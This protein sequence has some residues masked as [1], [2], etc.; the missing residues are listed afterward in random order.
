MVNSHETRAR[1]GRAPNLEPWLFALL[2]LAHLLPIWGV[3]HFVTDDGPTHLY[4]AWLLKEYLTGGS[5]WISEIYRLNLF[6]FPNLVSHALMTPLLLA[7]PPWIVWKLALSLHV[8]ALPLSARYALVGL[9]RRNAWLSWLAFPFIF[10]VTF[11][12]GFLNLNYSLA[13]WFLIIGFWWRRRLEFC[14]RDALGLAA[15]GVLIYFC[16]PVATA[17]V[18]GCLGLLCLWHLFYV[19]FKRPENRRVAFKS[20]IR[21][22]IAGLPTIALLLIFVLLRPGAGE[23]HEWNVAAGIWWFKLESLATLNLVHRVFGNLEPWF[24]RLYALGAAIGLLW[25]GWRRTK[26]FTFTQFDGLI[27]LFC[28][29]LLI[30]LV[31]PSQLSGANFMTKRLT[32]YPWFVLLLALATVAWPRGLRVT[33]QTVAAIAALGIVTTHL[34]SMRPLSRLTAEYLSLGQYLAPGERILPITWNPH[35][36]IPGQPPLAPGYEAFLHTA[37]L[38]AVHDKL[39][40]AVNYEAWMD[41]FPLIYREG[42]NPR[43]VLIDHRG[44]VIPGHIKDFQG[45]TAKPVDA[46]ILWHTGSELQRERI[47][48]LEGT[49]AP[50]YQFTAETS[51]Q[52]LGRLYRRVDHQ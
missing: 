15:L 23:S 25:L 20:F 44:Q 48:E 43:R 3:R 33:L 32:F 9:N 17:M 51:P 11:Y 52:G 28:A 12:M 26:R 18:V 45:K 31:V 46:V 16:H 6:P 8:I 34:Y 19:L 21:V 39:D 35:G 30:Y 22:L 14:W 2:I 1:A 47:D 7:L 38:L 5:T 27:L 36:K 49:L 42:W 40:L 41:H 29:V 37:D 24:V 4:N 50:T 13:L 10:N